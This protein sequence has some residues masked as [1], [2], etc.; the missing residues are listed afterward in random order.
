MRLWHHLL[1]V[2]VLLH[3][4]HVVGVSFSELPSSIHSRIKNIGQDYVTYFGTKQRWRMFKGPPRHSHRFEIAM[5]GDDNTWQKLYRERSQK[6]TW[7]SEQFDHYRWRE[8]LK[9][10]NRGKRRSAFKKLG[11]RLATDIF[12][13][14]PKAQAVRIRVRKGRAPKPKPGKRRW[15]QFK[16]V[17]YERIISRGDL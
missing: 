14:F 16:D 12:V 7:R 5:Q 3:L 1:A 10:F 8:K 17:T 2:F 6:Y 13:E 11:E 15:T 4:V 9:G